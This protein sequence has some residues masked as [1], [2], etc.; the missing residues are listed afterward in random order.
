MIYELASAS[1]A[2]FAPIVCI[3]AVIGIAQILTALF[4]V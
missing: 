3:V 4:D 1:W 2:F